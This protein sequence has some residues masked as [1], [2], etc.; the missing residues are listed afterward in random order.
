MVSWLYVD[1]SSVDWM[2]WKGW[3][4]WMEGLDELDGRL[5]GIG[6]QI[7]IGCHSNNM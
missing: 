7:T 3:V 2:E 5:G 6:C 1:L 4:N